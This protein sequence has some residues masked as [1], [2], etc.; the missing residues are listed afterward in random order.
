VTKGCCILAKAIC[1][2]AKSYCK[3]KTKKESVRG[4]FPFG[5]F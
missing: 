1:I 2:F 3:I 4:A 5:L